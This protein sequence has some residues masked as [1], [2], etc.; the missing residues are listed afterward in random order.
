MAHQGVDL[1]TYQCS[2]VTFEDTVFSTQ[3]NSSLS[4][5]L[6]LSHTHTNSVQSPIIASLMGSFDK[7]KGQGLSTGSVLNRTSSTF[8]T[9]RFITNKLKTID[10]PFLQECKSSLTLARS[11][12][13]PTSPAKSMLVVFNTTRERKRDR[14]RQERDRECV[15]V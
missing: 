7:R 4:P 5:S 15:C 3:L 12:I 14:E 6:F 2:G 9:S 1:Y 11:R 10:K 8:Y 13:L